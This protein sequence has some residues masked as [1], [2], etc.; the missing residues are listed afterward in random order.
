V[1]YSLPAVIE[2]LGTDVQNK[3]FP[4]YPFR[5]AILSLF[6]PFNQQS[7]L[8]EECSKD[9][10]F[11]SRKVSPEFYCFQVFYGSRDSRSMPSVKSRN[12]FIV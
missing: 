11:M 8:S 12:D 5:I 1:P 6:C 3:D 10:N 2:R 7:C 4:L 9:A